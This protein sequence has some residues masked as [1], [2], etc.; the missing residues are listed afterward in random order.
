LK[1]RLRILALEPYFGLS[2]RLFLEGYARYSRHEV[3]IW[4][5][6]PRKWKW[7]MR[8]SAYHFAD[9]ARD[10]ADSR[11]PDVVFASDFLNLADWRALAPRRFAE[12]PSVLYFHENQVCYPLAE[13]APV[14]FHYGWINLSS[15]LAADDVIF[16]SEYQRREF[17]LEVERVLDRMPDFVPDRCRT[18]LRERSSVFPV[19]IDFEAHERLLEDRRPWRREAPVILWN[20]RWEYDKN[21]DHFV[22]ALFELDA[23]RSRFEVTVCGESFGK[24]HPAFERLRSGLG[25]RVRHIGFVPS[26]ED[27]LRLVADSDVVASTARHE[28]FGVSVVEAIFLR[29]LPVLP[30]DLSYPEIVPPHLH[31]LF[32]YHG[33]SEFSTFLESFLAE[34]PLDFAGEVFE[35]ARRFHWRELAP[36]LDDRMENFASAPRDR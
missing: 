25:H 31:P 16:N 30:N 10:V 17:L 8:G 14:D 19:G 22:D 7:R 33:P 29:C 27:Y 28:F 3:E 11:I 5:L 26:T 13:Q 32:L 2:H 24:T 12:L 20:H 21:P 18:R 36:L 23:R 9:R 4:H 35:C 34:P 6:P 1:R 15:A